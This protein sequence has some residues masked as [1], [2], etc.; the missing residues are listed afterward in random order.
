[1]SSSSRTASHVSSA[2]AARDS[3][4]LTAPTLTP[5]DVPTSRCVRLSSHFWRRISRALR[6]DSLSVGMRPGVHRGRL[7]HHGRL[8]LAQRP[9]TTPIRLFTMPIR[10]STIPIPVFT[11][12]R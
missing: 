2:A 7:C 4:R 12:P 3:A 10:V 5:T 11:Q 1:M 6:I 8:R 9:A